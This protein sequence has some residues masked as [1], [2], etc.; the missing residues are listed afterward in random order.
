MP[1]LTTI[2]RADGI[3]IHGK[4]IQRTAVRGVIQRGRELLMIYSANA[5]D[6]QL[7]ITIYQFL[8]PAINA[9]VTPSPPSLGWASSN[10][11]TYECPRKASR[12]AARSLPVPLPCTIRTNGNPARYA[13]SR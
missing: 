10:D 12:T 5:G 11:F 9:T 7:P 8:H 4:T 6:Y 13:F 1:L 2:H 3:N